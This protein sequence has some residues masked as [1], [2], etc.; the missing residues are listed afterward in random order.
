MTDN[1]RPVVRTNGP[2]P[3][4][5]ASTWGVVL[6]A[7]GSQRGTDR[8]ECSCAW[9]DLAADPP[10]W[11]L[12]CPSTPQGLQ[13]VADHLQTALCLNPQQIV[14]SCLEFI[15]PY[16]EEAV[17]MLQGRGFRRVA[18]LPFFLGS[19]KHATLELAEIV[20]DMRVK[21]PDVQLYLAEGLGADPL[22]A[23][24]VVQRIRG[25]D[26]PSRFQPSDG[27][28]AGILLVK[29]GTKTIYDDC[30]WLEE[31]GVMVEHRLG[32]GYAVG[33]AQSHYGVPT[34]PAA[35]KRLVEE[36]QASSITYVPYLFFPGIILKRNVLEGM[37]SLQEQYPDTPMAVTPPLGPDERVVSVAA[38]R[39]RDLWARANGDGL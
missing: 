1:A 9:A 36:R 35:A 6:L 20:G 19:G 8:S 15:E 2:S 5:D 39:V 18:L 29:A 32:P 3:A 25:I 24:L 26:S 37:A 33:V 7:H 10:N 13:S 31:L 14:L 38:Q 22:M 30:R 17:R 23:N 27:H 4:S 34:M 11:C 12:E 21:A 16:P 28:T